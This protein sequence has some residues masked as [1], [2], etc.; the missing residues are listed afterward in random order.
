[1]RRQGGTTRACVERVCSI[2]DGSVTPCFIQRH[3]VLHPAS[4]R[5]SSSVTPCF[6][7]RH[8]VHLHAVHVVV[9]LR[10]AGF[11]VASVAATPAEHSDDCE[12][13]DARRTSPPAGVSALHRPQTIGV[14]RTASDATSAARRASP[15]TSLGD[16]RTRAAHGSFA[17]TRATHCRDA[18]AASVPPGCTH[19]QPRT[20]TLSSR[21]RSHCHAHPHKAALQQTWQRRTS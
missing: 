12:C 9:Q 20:C 10:H 13:R 16:A 14:Q 7:Q 15:S 3:A 2:C 6:I 17:Q 4:R 8:A 5:A 19:T 18:A 1:M 21:A 11:Q